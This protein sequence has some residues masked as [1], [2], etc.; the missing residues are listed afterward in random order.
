MARFFCASEDEGEQRGG[1]ISPDSQ[2]PRSCAARLVGSATMHCISILIIS[3]QME[4]TDFEQSKKCR[5]SVPRNQCCWLHSWPSFS[6][7]WQNSSPPHFLPALV[8]NLSSL[9]ESLRCVCFHSTLVRNLE[10]SPCAEAIGTWQNSLDGSF[11]KG[12][13]VDV[14]DEKTRCGEEVSWTK[15]RVWKSEH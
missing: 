3:G 14:A 15:H 8:W 6:V 11:V 4:R 5:R 9:V 13:S 10:G 12:L 7:F 2:S 1:V